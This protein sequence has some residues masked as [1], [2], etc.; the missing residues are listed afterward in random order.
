MPFYL[1]CLGYDEVKVL[2][3]WPKA[4]ILRVLVQGNYKLPQPMEGKTQI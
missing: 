1:V 4:Q 3:I 2:T